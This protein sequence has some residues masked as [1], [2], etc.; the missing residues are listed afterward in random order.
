M[1]SSIEEKVEEIF[2]KQLDRFKV[3]H[4]TKTES[5]NP[6][7]DEAL[8]N[9]VSKSGGSGNNYPDIKVLI[10]TSKMRRIPVMIEAKGI[11]GKLVKLTKSNDIELVTKWSSDSKEGAKNPHKAGDDN[12][13]TI[14]SYAV[15]G[16]I[17]YANAILDGKGYSE[18]IA[19]GVNGYKKSG[20]VEVEIEAYYVS[21]K[22]NR[23]PKR[24]PKVKDLSFLKKN[25][26]DKLADE[27]DKLV[28]S[29]KELEALAKKVE[30]TLED[31]IKA[32][33]Q[34]LYDN[35]KFKNYLTTNE[36]LYLFT[37]II[38]SGLSTEGLA[39]IV[40]TDFKGNDDEEDND[41]AVITKRIKSFLKKK[42]C[43]DDKIK[44]ILDL[45]EPVFSK[46]ALWKPEN[47]ESAIRELYKQV[48]ED[49]IPCLESNLHLDF[50]GKIFNSLNDWVSIENDQ[51]NDVVLTPRYVATLM[52][53]LARTDKDSFVWDKAMGSA[54]FLVAAMDIMIK[55][56]QSKIKDKDELESKIKKI[57][58]N[59]LL[60]IEI[61]GN[62]YILAV[63]NMILMGD[64]S[65]N[66]I[67]NDSFKYDGNFPATVFLLNPPYSASGKGFN[68]VEKALNQMTKGYA[69]ILIQE[70]AGSGQGDVY[71]KNILKKNTLLASIHMPNDLFS[72]KSS[73]QTA[74]YVFQVARPHEED[75][76]VKFIDFSNDGYSRTN[77][78]KSSQEVN[79]RDTDHAS[80][81]YAEI[82]AIVLG[83]K[84]KT[85]YYTE[86]N[87]LLIKDCIS[88]KGNDW[89]Y[90]QHKVIN[91]IP[92]DNDFEDT[93]KNYLS[94]KVNSLIKENKKI[95]LKKHSASKATFKEFSVLDFFDIKKGKRLTKA[96]MI[97]GDINFIGSTADNNGVTA[98]IGNT[99]HLHPGGTITVSYNGSVGEVFYQE[100][101]FW[102]SDDVNVWYPKEK[103]SIEI[104][105]YFM[106]AIKKLSTRYNYNAKWTLE[107][108]KAEKINLP[109]TK[110][111][112]IN[113]NYMTKYIKNIEKDT[114]TELEIFKNSIIETY[115]T[116]IGE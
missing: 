115:K 28:L 88:L 104:M 31:K 21:E 77:R 75:D 101:K 80:D 48:K 14:Q 7:I 106:T 12:Y 17:H 67:N 107:K 8:R 6:S 86:E 34:N 111:G 30:A 25:N 32:I 13:S 54:G 66:M 105:Q 68:F 73:V 114:I 82:E 92:T 65:S 47:G 50:T 20:D 63:L 23:V 84:T 102:A 70:N 94:W 87:G 4:F 108:M 64:G 39:P 71:T 42:K 79:L 100:D 95:V 72:G 26:V 56:A 90:N 62:I 40:M 24:I 51:Q 9:S 76:I 27:L 5:I 89:T 81:R 2:K 61:L 46:E 93:V 103:W 49:I 85:S 37:G 16:A 18:V 29:K 57:K 52:A 55:D 35:E 10:E 1:A 109:V 58:E 19:V 22:N 38:M 45:I 83:K 59:Q 43:D 97:D 11:K 96:Q 91:T 116:I 3:K 110:T 112:K 60:G 74:I 98:K 78:K 69:A 53:H 15:N 99:E 36:K 41:S 113:Y 44:M 33:H